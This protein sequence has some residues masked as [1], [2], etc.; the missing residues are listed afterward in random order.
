MKNY[1]EIMAEIQSWDLPSPEGKRFDQQIKKLVQRLYKATGSSIFP[2]AYCR[3][4]LIEAS[5]IKAYG[6]HTTTEEIM[7]MVSE[8]KGRSN[9]TS[10]TH[11]R[12]SMDQ[13]ESP[14]RILVEKIYRNSD[15]YTASTGEYALVTL[16]E[17][18]WL[19]TEK[20]SSTFSS[21]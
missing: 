8:W 19:F 6:A 21:R 4:M 5:W 16:P 3:K 2:E 10:W 20:W 9:G 15:G 11:T 14:Q 18:R 12:F 13:L 7:G 17:G 1:S